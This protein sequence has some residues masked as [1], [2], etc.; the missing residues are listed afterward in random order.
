MQVDGRA[1]EVPATLKPL[2]NHNS[3]TH[4]YL[5]KSSSQKQP[6]NYHPV[7]ENS[8]KVVQITHKYENKQKQPVNH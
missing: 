3:H 7:T 5:N 1:A 2:P 8:L 6:V 4:S